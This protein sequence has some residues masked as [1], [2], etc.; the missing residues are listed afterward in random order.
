APHSV[1][2]RCRIVM[3]DGWCRRG[4]GRRS[5]F[6]AMNMWRPVRH[7]QIGAIMFAAA[8]GGCAWAANGEHNA[9]QPELMANGTYQPVA[10]CVRNGLAG[11]ERDVVSAVD[12]AERRARIW[13]PLPDP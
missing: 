6:P 8:L 7:H 13:R 10:A 1:G 12:P 4:D 5:R 2:Q 9:A 3:P 11:Q